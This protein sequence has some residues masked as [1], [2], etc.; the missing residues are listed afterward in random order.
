VF[1]NLGHIISEEF[2]M[3]IYKQ[4]DGSKAVGIDGIT[5]SKFGENLEGNI[6][7]IIH[8]IRRGKYK[9]KAARLVEI[10]KEDGSFR[11]LAISCFRDKLVQGATT[12]IMNP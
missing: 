6:K 7:E 3:E 2:L 9:P 10:P 4:L 8:E 5:K 11:P 12:S 1:N